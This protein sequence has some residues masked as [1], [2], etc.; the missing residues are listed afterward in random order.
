[1]HC[2]NDAHERAKK[3]KLL[4][5]DVDGTLTD[6]KIIYDSGGAE[7]KEFSARDGI[8]IRVAQKAGLK[9]VIITGRASIAL[10]TRAKELDV[11]RFY[12]GR[13]RKMPALDEVLVEFSLKPDEVAYI[14]DD[15]NDIPVMSRVGLAAAVPGAPEEVARIAHA[16]TTA[17]G[18][19]GAVREFIEFILKSQGR[20]EKAVQSFMDD[21]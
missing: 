18:G 21:L 6:G 15:L 9:T 4:A 13:Q 12:T 11:S 19:H 10:A 17:P 8:G 3:I 5:M 7:I 16:C 20:W 14:G 1:M 2:T